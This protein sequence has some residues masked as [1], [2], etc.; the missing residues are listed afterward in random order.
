MLFFINY[1]K[2][3][4]ITADKN[5]K[6]HF[7]FGLF[8]ILW[9]LSASHAS[10]LVAVTAKTIQGT[11][12]YL[13][14]VDGTTKIT[15]SNQLIGLVMW[16]G[17]YD[18]NGKKHTVN[19]DASMSNKSI[20]IPAGMTYADVIT[21]ITTDGNLHPIENLKVGSDDG[22]AINPADANITGEMK[23]TWYNGGSKVN[24]LSQTLPACEGP[25]TLEVEIPDQIEV[26]TKY[27]DPS[28]RLYSHAAVTYTFMQE[29]LTPCHFKPK[30]LKTYTGTEGET[31]KFA[32][33]YNPKTW[34]PNKG[35][36]AES[37]FPETG[38]YKAQFDLIWP[39]NDQSHYRCKSTDDSG[40][41]T[42]SGAVSTS[43]GENCSVTYNVK[44]KSEFIAG[45]NTPTIDVEYNINGNWE[46]VGSYTIPVPKKW[47]IVIGP[48]NFGDATYVVNAKTFPAIDECRLIVDGSNTPAT[49]TAQV[50]DMSSEAKAWRQKYMYRRNELTNSPLISY[51]EMGQAPLTYTYFS[52]DADGTFMGEWGT[53]DDYTGSNWDDSLS[54]MWQIE[55]WSKD[56]M[57]IVGKHGGIGNGSLLTLRSAPCRG[58]EN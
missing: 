25:F 55:L 11:Q 9:M 39:G 36:K 33:G 4:Y 42:L 18:S 20:K 37:P 44:K 7:L 30:S 1:L 22:D 12:P 6:F 29:N 53:L 56:L 8:F 21:A 48:I 50:L 40:K 17:T 14:Q 51:D 28:N 49:T 32:K 45:G 2:K 15:D 47:A 24:D 35:F 57:Y 52:R 3:N 34:E 54:Y 27:G 19:I 26:K 58:D 46:K 31:I 10:A 13:L 16:D 23:A 41:I 5:I 38:F 43:L